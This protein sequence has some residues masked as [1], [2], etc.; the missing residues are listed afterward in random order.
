MSRNDKLTR[1]EFIKRSHAMHGDKF[2]YSLVVYKNTKSKVVLKCKDCGTVFEQIVSNHLRGFGCPQC[3]RLQP[4]EFI[5]KAIEV[6]GDKFDYTPTVYTTRRNNVLIRCKEC[7]EVFSVR[8]G[9]HL[10][11]QGC[12][13]CWRDRLTTEKFIARAKEKFGDK[14]D[15]SPT[16]YVNARTK[17]KFICPVHGIVEQNP[18]QHLRGIGCPLCDDD[19]QKMTTE[20]FIR[21]ARE[22]HRD[23]YDYSLV[24][25]TTRDRKVK[26]ICKKHGVFEQQAGNHLSGYH[27]PYC[28]TSR[29]EIKVKYWLQDNGVGFKWQ[30]TLRRK[31]KEKGLTKIIIDFYIKDAKTVIEYNGQQH[32]EPVDIYGGKE[33]FAKQ[34]E[35]DKEVER[36]CKQRKLNLLIIPYTDYD[37]IGEILKKEL[38]PLIK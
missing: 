30:H 15:Y 3:K 10:D 1:E 37:R 9:H 11:G 2:D 33:Q 12:P 19:S 8:A 14:Y 6:H 23:L 34:L 38:L 28:A 35:R 27:C 22:V 24:E 7:G 13:I 17:I 25:Y 5:K 32:Y 36:I 21:K 4:D 20:D 31:N 18:L 16:I 29:G 26:I